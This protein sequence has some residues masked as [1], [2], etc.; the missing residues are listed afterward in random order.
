MGAA[1]EMAAEE[2]AAQKNSNNKS[3]SLAMHVSR[4]VY[5]QFAYDLR[6]FSNITIT[7]HEQNNNFETIIRCCLIFLS[8]FISLSFSPYISLYSLVSHLRQQ[9]QIYNFMFCQV[10]HKIDDKSRESENDNEREKKR[11]F[12]SNRCHLTCIVANGN[13]W[14]VVS[15]SLVIFPLR[16]KSL[17]SRSCSFLHHHHLTSRPSHFSSSSEFA[18]TAI[19]WLREFQVSQPFSAS[20]VEHFLPLFHRYH[21]FDITVTYDTSSHYQFHWEHFIA[22]CVC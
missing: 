22:N 13:I 20:I 21:R 17:L 16:M 4:L 5:L 15:N 18:T 3:H 11:C 19:G 7:K 12:D 6:Q 10:E 14:A 2:A 9:R 1:E 8:D